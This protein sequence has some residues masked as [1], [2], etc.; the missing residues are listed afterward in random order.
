[1][2]A[3]QDRPGFYYVDATRWGCNKSPTFPTFIWISD[4]ANPFSESL[5]QIRAENRFDR[6]CLK[7]YFLQLHT[8]SEIFRPC[9]R[10]EFK[11]Y[12][13]LVLGSL[14]IYVIKR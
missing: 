5:T 14:V 13:L 2:R 10:D 4:L 8:M 9:C 3:S 6:K 12:I 7:I 1:M 11:M